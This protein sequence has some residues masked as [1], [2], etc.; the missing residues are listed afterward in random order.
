MDTCMDVHT[1]VH[2][3]VHTVAMLDQLPPKNDEPQ[4]L[5]PVVQWDVVVL[6]Q[7]DLLEAFDAAALA[8]A[9]VAATVVREHVGL[10]QDLIE[11][12]AGGFRDVL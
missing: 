1:S 4:I 5:R 3:R 6:L 9:L 2:I 8:Q 11:D 10:V 12:H 7:Y